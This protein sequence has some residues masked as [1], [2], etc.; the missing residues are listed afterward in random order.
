LEIAVGTATTGNRVRKPAYFRVVHGQATADG[1]DRLD[2]A[3]EPE[4]AGDHVLDRVAPRDLLDLDVDLGGVQRDLHLLSNQG[5]HAI[6]VEQ[7]DPTEAVLAQVLAEVVERVWLDPR[8]RGD[9]NLHR[10]RPPR[11]QESEARASR[12]M[13]PTLS[14]TN[15]GR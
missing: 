10:G 8:Q 4:R 3:R 5:L 7:R 11:A 2:R 6:P 9:L 15:V 12:S 13:S 1:H 14:N